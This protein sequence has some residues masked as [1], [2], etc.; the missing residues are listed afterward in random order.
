[1]VNGSGLTYRFADCSA[2]SRATSV[3]RVVVG[4]GCPMSVDKWPEGAP[5]KRIWV[6]HV[7]VETDKIQMRVAAARA[8]GDLTESQEIIADGVIE[9]RQTGSARGLP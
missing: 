6:Q 8:R 4:R 1:M 9:V 3:T 5:R 7:A 2:V